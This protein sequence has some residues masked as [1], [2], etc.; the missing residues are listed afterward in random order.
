MHDIAAWR[1]YL[2]ISWH[3]IVSFIY[4]YIYLLQDGVTN[5]GDCKYARIIILPNIVIMLNIITSPKSSS[6]PLF[7]HKGWV[8][9]LTSWSGGCYGASNRC[10]PNPPPPPWIKLWH[11][12]CYLQRPKKKGFLLSLEVTSVSFRTVKPKSLTTT[13]STAVLAGKATQADCNCVKQGW[14]LWEPSIERTEWRAPGQ[15]DG[16]LATI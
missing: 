9:L 2:P 8:L 13:K 7:L 15:Y 10:I 4:I 14:P 6:P 1:S 11:G 3:T 12:V 5:Y 16:I